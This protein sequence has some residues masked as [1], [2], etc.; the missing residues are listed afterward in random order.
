MFDVAEAAR[1]RPARGVSIAASIN[2]IG[3]Q[4][5]VESAFM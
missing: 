3:A 5:R 1:A 2:A 4:K